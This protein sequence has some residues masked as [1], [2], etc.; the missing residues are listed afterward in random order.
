MILKQGM[1]VKVVLFPEGQDPDSYA[2]NHSTEELENFITSNAKDFIVFKTDILLAETANDPIQKAKLIHEI[3]DSIALIP[4]QISRTV[5]ITE[6][7]NLLGIPE[8]TLISELNKSLRK[9]I[10]KTNQ[11]LGQGPESFVVPMDPTPQ[12]NNELE[13]GFG[14]EEKEKEVIRLL[15]NYPYHVFLITENDEEGN[16]LEKIEINTV[17]YISEVLERDEITFKNKIYQKILNEYILALNEEKELSINFF[18]HHSDPEISKTAID[19]V[20]SKHE[21]HNWKEQN[22]DVIGEDRKLKRAVEGTTNSLLVA[23]IEIMWKDNQQKLKTAKPEEWGELIE[24]QK[25][26]T[27]LRAIISKAQGRDV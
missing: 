19:I 24:M 4:D 17:S 27:Q 16:I 11:Q 21:L 18:T 10:N 20:T 26:L 15:L 7:S 6:C 23:N 2:K 9:S 1:N 8:K 3:V 5:Y 13:E 25:N 14:L 12:Q 22:I